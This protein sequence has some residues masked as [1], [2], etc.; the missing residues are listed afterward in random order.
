MKGS[1][2]S[3]PGFLLVE[4][5]DI[6]GVEVVDILAT[7]DVNYANNINNKNGNDVEIVRRKEMRVFSLGSE[8]YIV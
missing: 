5:R 8:N 1:I 6:I 3:G 2:C 7:Q 4:V